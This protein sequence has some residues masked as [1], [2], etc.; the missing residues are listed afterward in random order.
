MS[1]QAPEQGLPVFIPGQN[2]PFSMTLPIPRC[3]LGGLSGCPWLGLQ[4]FSSW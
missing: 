3:G 4:L 2:C 1:L